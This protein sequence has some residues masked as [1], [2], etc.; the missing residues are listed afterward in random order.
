MGT[1]ITLALVLGMIALGAF[2]VY[3]LTGRDAERTVNSTPAPTMPGALAA[4]HVPY[5]APPLVPPSATAEVI[6][7]EA[8]GALALGAGAPEEQRADVHGLEYSDTLEPGRAHPAVARM[9][10]VQWT[11]G[12]GD[13]ARPPAG[14]NV[15]VHVI[16]VNP[17]AARQVVAVLRQA[18]VCSEPRSHPIAT[19]EGDTRLH[20][21]V[22][23]L[24]TGMSAPA[25]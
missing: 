13:G 24:H 6:G 22:D 21:T 19:G 5:P 8:V 3:L 10:Q 23:T 2:L 12:A 15:E 14:G 4:P 17:D 20:L 7:M 16:A 18:L 1:G 11:A 9:S 25:A